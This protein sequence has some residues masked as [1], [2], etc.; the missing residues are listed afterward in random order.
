MLGMLGEEVASHAACQITQLPTT[1][2]VQCMAHAKLGWPLYALWATNY[3]AVQ[4]SVPVAKCVAWP[5]VPMTIAAEKY[6]RT[7]EASAAAASFWLCQRTWRFTEVSPLAACRTCCHKQEVHSIVSNSVH[8]SIT[9]H[10]P[11]SFGFSNAEH[12]WKSTIIYLLSYSWINE[13]YFEWTVV[14]CIL[15]HDHVP[16]SCDPCFP[17]DGLLLGRIHL[18][19]VTRHLLAMEIVYTETNRYKQHCGVCCILYMKHICNYVKWL[20]DQ[21]CSQVSWQSP[22]Y[23]KPS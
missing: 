18:G 12:R 23:C 22:W 9:I 8:G 13:I 1:Q 11:S 16:V 3:S 15:F 4:W 6:C 7:F 20:K 17:G 5:A 10:Y 14:E 19:Y 21:P 2:N